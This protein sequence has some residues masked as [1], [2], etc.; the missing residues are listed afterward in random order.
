MVLYIISILEKKIIRLDISKILIFYI[1]LN[2]SLS[3]KLYNTI[4]NRVLD[5]TLDNYLISSK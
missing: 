1:L 5:Y 4:D 2:I 3:I